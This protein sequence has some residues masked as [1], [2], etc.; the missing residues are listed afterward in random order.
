MRKCDQKRLKKIKQQQKIARCKN[1]FRA[2]YL[3]CCIGNKVDPMS[4][5]IEVLVQTIQLTGLK[6]LKVMVANP[7]RFSLFPLHEHIIRLAKDEI[8]LRALN[9]D[10]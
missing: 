9:L 7:G 6:D 2:S 8:V 10:S 4:P 3:S 5:N 1:R